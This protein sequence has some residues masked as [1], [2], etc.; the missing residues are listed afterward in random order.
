MIPN[1]RASI[2]VS[3]MEISKA[4]FAVSNVESI[5]AGNTLTSPNKHSFANPTIKAMTK[6][7]IHI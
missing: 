6:N 4:L 2:P 5:M 1:Q 3:P 7:A